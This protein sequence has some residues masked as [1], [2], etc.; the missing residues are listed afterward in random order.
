M[1]VVRAVMDA[2]LRI[3]QIFSFITIYW[4]TSKIKT[5]KKQSGQRS[6]GRGIIMASA[7]SGTDALLKVFIKPW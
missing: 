5:L 7:T 1:G 4:I 2:N 3:M 6:D